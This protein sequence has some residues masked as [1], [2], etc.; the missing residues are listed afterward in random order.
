VTFTLTVHDPEAG[1]VA[2]VVWP[3]SSVVAPAAGAHEGEPPQVVD[4]AGV[5]ATSTPDGKVSLNFAPVRGAELELF[6][7][8]V[9]VEV[10]FTAIGSGENDLLI[11]GSAGVAHPVK[12]TSSM[13]KSEPGLSLTA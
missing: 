8:N 13:W 4:A 11:V 5:A 9:S 3:K 10:P 1:I 12:R 7:V 6:S 2:P